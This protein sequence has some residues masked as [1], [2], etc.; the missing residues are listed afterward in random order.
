[1][2]VAKV[3]GH[4]NYFGITGNSRALGCFW[5][6]VKRVWKKWL[7]RRSGREQM[8]WERFALLVGRYPL[9]WPRVV[10]SVYRR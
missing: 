6:E 4:Y 3:R 5:Y 1:M 8:T 7:G 9:P 10:H 2:L